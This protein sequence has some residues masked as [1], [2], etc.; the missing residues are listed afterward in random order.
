LRAV[1]AGWTPEYGETVSV[2]DAG[3]VS[4]FNQVA[5]RLAADVAH[6]RH[7]YPNL[8]LSGFRVIFANKYAAVLSVFACHA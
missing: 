3:G 8:R 5:M 4:R 6:Q 1:E 7:S 2:D